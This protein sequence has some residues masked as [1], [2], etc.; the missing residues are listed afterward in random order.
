MTQSQQIVIGDVHGH[1]EA[2]IKLLEALA[3]GDDDEVYFVGDLIDRGPE[4]ARVVDF[5]IKQGYHC[6]L[7]NHEQMMLDAVGGGHISPQLLQAWL[8]SGGYPTLESYNHQIPEDHLK[9]MQRLPLYFDLGDYW[10]VHAGV[11]PSLPI[12]EQGEDQFCWIREG[13]HQHPEP[14]F[15]DKQI[16]TGHTITFT[17]P[18]I[19]PGKIVSGPGWIDIDTGAYHPRSGWLT[20]LELNQQEVIQVHTNSERTRRLPLDKAMVTID[21]DSLNKR[22]RSP[23]KTGWFS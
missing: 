3:L 6:L 22:R 8:H 5:V 7:G 18:N 4:S 19:E 2:L 11:D 15:S 13:F 1:Y 9:W 17:F 21:P 23:K 12:V 14:Y 16:I 20:A 10:I